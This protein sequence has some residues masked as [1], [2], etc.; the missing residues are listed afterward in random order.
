LSV[1]CVKLVGIFFLRAAIARA[2]PPGPRHRTLRSV[3]NFAQFTNCE[4]VRLTFCVFLALNKAEGSCLSYR[5]RPE[6][7]EGCNICGERPRAVERLRQ[8]DPLVIEISVLAP[9]SDK[10]FQ[11]FTESA[12]NILPP[13][14]L[15]GKDIM[16]T[17]CQFIHNHGIS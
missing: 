6:H 13:Q 10:N 5:A 16:S 7:V 17:E 2:C 3:I 8:F 1:V 15:S 4:L 9:F 11:Q 12:K 14:L